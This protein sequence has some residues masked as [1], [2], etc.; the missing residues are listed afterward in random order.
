MNV[1]LSWRHKEHLFVILE[2]SFAVRKTSNVRASSIFHFPYITRKS[3]TVGIN[4]VSKRFGMVIIPLFFKLSFNQSK[5]YFFL[6][7]GCCSTFPYNFFLSGITIEGTICLRATVTIKNPFCF[8]LKNLFVM[9]FD[10]LWHVLSTNIAYF[11]SVFVK[12]LER[13][14]CFSIK[15]KNIFA[16]FC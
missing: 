15:F 11:N 9:S 1:S 10:Y 2:Y 3:S 5:I 13:W 4:F 6:V 12:K 14:K 8:F 16:T 7:T